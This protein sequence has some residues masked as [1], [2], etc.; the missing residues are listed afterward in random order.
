ME[1]AKYLDQADRSKLD[2]LLREL[3]KLKKEHK[4]FAKNVGKLT[5]EERERWRVNSARTNEVHI[6]IKDLRQK[7][8]L[9]AW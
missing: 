3:E 9:V 5:P 8:I 2:D 7:N 1:D 6:A 4:A